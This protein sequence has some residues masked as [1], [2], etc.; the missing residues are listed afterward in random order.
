MDL[1]TKRRQELQI[2]IPAVSYFT[3]FSQLPPH[4]PE[5][6]QPLHFVQDFFFFLKIEYM[7]SP[8]RSSATAPIMMSAIGIPKIIYIIPMFIMSVPNW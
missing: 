5:Y 3:L 6:G 2:A 4:F 1:S 7:H 8:T